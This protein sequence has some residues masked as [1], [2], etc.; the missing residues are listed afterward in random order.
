[1]ARALERLLPVIVARLVEQRQEGL[2]V[3]T[4][5]HIQGQAN[6]PGLTRDWQMGLG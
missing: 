3:N 5:T 1:M 6:G 2:E 4:Y